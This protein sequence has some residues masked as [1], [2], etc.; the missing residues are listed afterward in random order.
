MNINETNI[1]KIRSWMGKKDI[2][3]RMP[4]ERHPFG[5]SVDIGWAL[6][7]RLWSYTRDFAG[8]ALVAWMDWAVRQDDA[9]RDD[10]W[11]GDMF[12][13]Y[14]RMTDFWHQV[15]GRPVIE[16]LM[17]PCLGYE[18]DFVPEQSA[19]RERYRV[20]SRRT[21]VMIYRR[22][23][24]LAD[25]VIFSGLSS[26]GC[27]FL[28]PTHK[29]L[30]ETM[31]HWSVSHPVTMVEHLVDTPTKT[32]SLF[33]S[34][35]DRAILLLKRAHENSRSGQNF[36]GDLD[37]WKSAAGFLPDSAYAYILAMSPDNEHLTPLLEQLELLSN[38]PLSATG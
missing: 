2:P 27:A 37:C 22:A 23:L 26:E 29:A 34:W 10:G 6:F 11:R 31:E 35:L 14:Q 16:V 7:S 1:P 32:P 17:D 36:V 18:M 4:L 9:P 21:Q 30:A 3:G 19:I 33:C 24:Q 25:G 12:L 5:R 13:M 8:F 28:A 38:R 20:L 15:P